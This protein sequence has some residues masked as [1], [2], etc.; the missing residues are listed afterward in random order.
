VEALGL[1]A[2]AAAPASPKVT[3][4]EDLAA[5][6][7][8]EVAAIRHLHTLGG[9]WLPQLPTFDINDFA[10]DRLRDWTS[11][12]LSQFL[13]DA[14][15]FFSRRDSS[16][17]VRLEIAASIVEAATAATAMRQPLAGRSQYGRFDPT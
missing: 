16:K 17:Q 5:K 13:G 10:A 12:L 11:G 6:L 8:A 7:G 3:S 9:G 14:L 1:F 4:L 15:M 2:K